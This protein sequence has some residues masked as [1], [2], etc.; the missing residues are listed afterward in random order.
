MLSLPEEWDYTLKG[1]SKINR[2]GID[3]IR[4][5]VNIG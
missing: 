1:L 5:I 2:E 3:A 4:D